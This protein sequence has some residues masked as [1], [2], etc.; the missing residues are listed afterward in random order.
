VIE[1]PDQFAAWDTWRGQDRYQFGLVSSAEP[2]E[3]GDPIP[4]QTSTLMERWGRTHDAEE[5]HALARSK[6]LE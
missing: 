3:N 1:A 4:I 5:F 2:D 6:G